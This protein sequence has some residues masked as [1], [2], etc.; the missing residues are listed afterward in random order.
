VWH[1]SPQDVCEGGAML[2]AMPGLMP[3]Y[4]LCTSTLGPSIKSPKQS[5]QCHT[6][7]WRVLKPAHI[8]S[9]DV[10]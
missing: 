1:I 7:S 4:R 5:T 3:G 10:S 2:W 8:L 6:V 9:E